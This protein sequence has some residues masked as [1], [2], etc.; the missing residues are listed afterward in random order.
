MV[1]ICLECINMFFFVEV[2]LRVVELLVYDIYIVGCWFY[3]GLNF[4]RLVRWGLIFE[5][6][7]EIRI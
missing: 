3:S 6:K 5:D 7:I 4:I 1:F 2:I